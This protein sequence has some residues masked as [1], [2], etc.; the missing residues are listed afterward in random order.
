MLTA[1]APPSIPTGNGIPIAGPGQSRIAAGQNCAAGH[2]HAISGA[3]ALP[4]VQKEGVTMRVVL[5]AAFAAAIAL[6]MPAANAANVDLSTITC[7]QF[8]NLDKDNIAV[9]ITWLDGYYKDED[10][11]PVIDFDSFQK[12]SQALGQFC[13]EHPDDGLIT[14]A[15]QSFGKK[16]KK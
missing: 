7:K 9:Y 16:K 14:A 10:D 13:H 3:L 5:G 11:P 4:R 12:N 6:A 2:N 15:D 8:V 1:G